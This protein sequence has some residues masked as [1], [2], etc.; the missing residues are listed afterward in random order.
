MIELL[1]TISCSEVNRGAIKSSGGGGGGGGA[2]GG[3]GGAGS[4]LIV[5]IAV[6][7][8]PRVAP[9]EGDVRV[10]LTVVVA[11]D[12]LWLGRIVIGKVCSE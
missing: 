6:L 11:A 12:W 2:G 8:A 9:P 4:S 3:G 5:R 1:L 10:R 7:V